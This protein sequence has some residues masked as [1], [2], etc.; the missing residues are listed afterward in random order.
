METAAIALGALAFLSFILGVWQLA[1]ALRFP[2]HRRTDAMKWKA[3]IT[4]LKPLKGFDANTEKCLRSW[5]R[6]QHDGPLQILFGI[7]APDDAAGPVVERLIRENPEMEARLIMCPPPCG[8]NGKAA[9][10]AR[11]FPEASHELLVISDAD[12]FA[13]PDVVAEVAAPL[14]HPQ[15]GLVFCFYKMTN[16]RG[17]LE[18]CAALGVNADFW[19]QVLQARCL[20]PLDFA[21][22]AVM[23]VRRAQ[24]KA[25]GGFEAVAEFLADDYEIGQRVSSSGKRIEICPRV[26]ECR[27]PT[28]TRRSVVQHQLRWARTIRVCRPISYGL[29][30]LANGTL[31][32]AAWLAMRPGGWS[33]WAATVFLGWR[34]ISALWLQ[35]RLTGTRSRWF[36][37]AVVVGKDTLSILYWAAAFLGSG[38]TWRGE[39][40]Q[41]RRDGRLQPSPARSATIP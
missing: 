35:S 30:I 16:G 28:R 20:K 26:V 12:V 38:V 18:R 39:T 34:I 17:V 5:F 15:T 31:W 14:C 4:V 21:S 10:L 11:L 32:P 24:I 23:A 27:E 22:G 1:V 3:G 7:A 33:A 41:I 40:F 2:L 13:E 19:S 29:S 9:T 36:D 37:P 25:M 6:Q 8:P